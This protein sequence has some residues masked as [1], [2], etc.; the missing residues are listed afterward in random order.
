MSEIIVYLY[1]K[2][3][4]S[5]LDKIKEITEKAKGKGNGN[6][7]QIHLASGNIDSLSKAIKTKE[8]ADEFMRQLKSL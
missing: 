4:D 3:K 2:M 6:A 8:Q 7:M 5:V 1:S